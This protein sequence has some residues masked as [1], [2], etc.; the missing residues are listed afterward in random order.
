MKNFAALDFET[1]NSSRQSVCS[2]GLVVVRQG[3]IVDRF[4]SLIKPVPD[5]YSKFNIEV[6]GITADDTK[7][8]PSFPQVWAQAE[9]K[10]GDLPLVAHNSAFD[11]SCLKA[12]MQ[13]YDMAYPGYRFYCTLRASKH[14]FGSRLPNHQLPT[15]ADAVGFDLLN[16]H[17]AMA[18]AE[19]C[20]AIAL[21]IL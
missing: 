14:H 13:H 7:N 3:L 11:E 12:V 4:Y 5:Y 9:T 18:D 21:A 2:L 17:D 20:A 19:A 6:H 10:I 8:A 15:V 1:A 16:H